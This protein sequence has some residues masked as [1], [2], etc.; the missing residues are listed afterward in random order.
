M[1]DT[2]LWYTTRASGMVSIVLLSVVTALGLLTAGR[3]GS[4]RWPCTATS[5]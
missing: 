5:R 2:I 1:N 4:T 3:A